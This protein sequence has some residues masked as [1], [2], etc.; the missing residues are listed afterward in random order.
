MF[1]LTK[2]QEEVKKW[3]NRNFGPSYGS[4]YRPLLGAIEE[5]GELA[6][7]HLKTEQNIRINE[8][9]IHNKKDAIGDI[10]IYLTDYCNGQGFSLEEILETTWNE[11]K[12]R[13]WNKNKEVGK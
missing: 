1:N 8:D 5:L 9:H 7:A 4:G 13:D 11:V 3:T 10:I 12:Q 2:F 6:H